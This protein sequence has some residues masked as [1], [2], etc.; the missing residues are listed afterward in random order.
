[1]FTDTKGLLDNGLE[2]VV[3]AWDEAHTEGLELEGRMDRYVTHQVSNSYT[4]AI[5]KAVGLVKTR[6][7]HVPEVGQCGAGLAADDPGAGSR[8]AAT[9]GPGAVHGRG[10]RAEHRR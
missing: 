3:N 6:P 1:M 7:D 10:L 8:N 2:L 4:N 5:I 9:R